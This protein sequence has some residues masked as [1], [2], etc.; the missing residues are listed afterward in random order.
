MT[1]L[2]TPVLAVFLCAAPAAAQTAN[3]T[4]V[5]TSCTAGRLDPLAGAV[6]ISVSGTPRLGGS[7]T[8]IT[9]G[10]AGLPTGLRRSVYLLTGVSNTSA[11]G[12]PL[13]FDLGALSPGE[14][15]CGMLRTSAE[16]VVRV[17]SA[18]TP[19]TPVSIRFDV[20]N[21]TALLGAMLYQ[22]VMSTEFSSFG[23]PFRSIALSAGGVATIGF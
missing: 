20:P 16:A 10:S 17:P 11:F 6:P 7:F 5:G 9:E 4:F 18:P 3:Y 21:T 15:I 23:P 22:Q 14:P 1:R 13:P 12:V 2:L 19:Q 8:V